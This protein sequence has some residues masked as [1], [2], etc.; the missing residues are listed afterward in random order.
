MNYEDAQATL[1]EIRGPA[2][3]LGQHTDEV[4]TETGVTPAEIED[5]RGK[6]VVG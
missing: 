6:G 5:L 3:T 4:L 1:A 2:P